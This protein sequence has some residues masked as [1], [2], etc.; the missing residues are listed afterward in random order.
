[1]PTEAEQQLEGRVTGLER[2]MQN[3]SQAVAQ[4]SETVSQGFRDTRELMA[5]AAR[6]QDERT[7]EIHHRLDKQ[8]ERSRWN[9][10]LI[11]ASITCAI[12]L[13]GIFISFVHMYVGPVKES[14][15]RLRYQTAAAADRELKNAERRGRDE[16]RLEGIARTVWANKA[17]P[18]AP[19]G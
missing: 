14:I 13:G 19:G 15:E 3:M 5:G 7:S 4:L 2:D 1:M 18:A 8:T 6:R 11:I 16:V 9:P 10:G 17:N 12:L